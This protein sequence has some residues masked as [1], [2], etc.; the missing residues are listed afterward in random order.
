MWTPSETVPSANRQRL[1]VG[2]LVDTSETIFNQMLFKGGKKT[3]AEP[4]VMSFV[5]YNFQTP[6]YKCLLA[7]TPGCSPGIHQAWIW[8]KYTMQELYVKNMYHGTS[9]YDLLLRRQITN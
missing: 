6:H 8:N 2:Q 1:K 5:K 3:V 7:H 9:S 4:F